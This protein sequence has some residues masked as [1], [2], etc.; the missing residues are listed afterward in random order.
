MKGRNQRSLPVKEGACW[1]QCSCKCHIG[2]VT[3]AE[4][5]CLGFSLILLGFF[6]YYIRVSQATLL[7]SSI[8]PPSSEVSRQT[9][10][11]M[12]QWNVCTHRATACLHQQGGLHTFW[13]QS[14]RGGR[15]GNRNFYLLFIFFFLLFLLFWRF[16][17]FFFNFKKRRHKISAKLQT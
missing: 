2:A 13:M 15:K 16:F 10:N 11:R 17:G 9:G 1:G 12:L 6:S 8:L 4:R 7:P 3:N 14:C 5:M